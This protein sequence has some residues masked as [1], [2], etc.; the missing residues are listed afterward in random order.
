MKIASFDDCKVG[1]VS[2]DFIHDVTA[3]LPDFLSH[4]PAQRINWL[5]EHWNELKDDI[6]KA[7]T[8]GKPI[9]LSSVRLQPANPGAPHIYAAPANY[10]K[11]IGELGDRAVTAGG[12]SA[13][14][15]GFFL[16]APASLLGSGGTILLPRDSK[17]RF[18]HESELAVIIGKIARD[19]RREDAMSYV[20]GYSCLIDGTMRIEKVTGE[21]ERTMRKSFDTFTPMGP[22]L[23][24]ADEIDDPESL[25]NRLWVN[26]ELRQSAN[27]RELIVGVAELIEMVSSVVTLRPGDVIA[28]GTPEGV[29]PIE[30]GD[31]VR[32]E[33]QK[34]G[35][36]TVNVAQRSDVAPKPY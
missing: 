14:E 6:V 10:R 9:P 15:Q 16:K 1:V 22:Y 20:F 13:R 35:S 28:T 23:V 32:I 29:G 18:D 25:D 17:R 4:L 5:I 8:C 31:V 27:T 33:I 21:E 34:V 36:M 30:Q 19:V 12:R 3:V 24:T 2:D 11:H 26:D 7:S